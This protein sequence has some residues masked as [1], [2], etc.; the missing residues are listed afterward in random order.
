MRDGKGKG[1]KS[2]APIILPKARFLTSNSITRVKGHGWSAVRVLSSS[3]S[4]GD[5]W[6][7]DVCSLLLFVRVSERRTDHGCS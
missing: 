3:N 6:V 2:G 1:R 7:G 5:G 4:G